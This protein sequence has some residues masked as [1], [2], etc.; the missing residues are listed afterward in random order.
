MGT[1]SWGHNHGDTIMGTQSWGHN[2]GD[3]IMGT[4]SWGHNHGDTIMG[5]QSWG[6]M[7]IQIQMTIFS[8]LLD[9]SHLSDFIGEYL[10]VQC[11][12]DL[13]RCGLILS[14]SARM[15]CL[16]SQHHCRGRLQQRY[17]NHSHHLHSLLH[18]WL[19]DNQLFTIK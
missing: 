3:T 4:Q 14:C 11:L 13:I 5:T 7:P 10:H 18:V 16:W 6:W 12:N 19:L 15:S 8:S 1:Q 9:N 2:H 17:K